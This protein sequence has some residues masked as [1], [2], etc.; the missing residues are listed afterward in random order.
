MT[1][2]G[3]DHAVPNGVVGAVSQNPGWLGLEEP[4]GPS[5]PPGPP[6]SGHED[7]GQFYHTT[8]G[9]NTRDKVV[10]LRDFA[11]DCLSSLLNT[12]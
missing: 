8:G 7:H 3:R 4:L 9:H 2:A 1:C 11:Y 12:Q 6:I 10:P 5:V